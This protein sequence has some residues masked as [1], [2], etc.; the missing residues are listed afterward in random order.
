M[1]DY[2]WY[3]ALIIFTHSLLS[4]SLPAALRAWPV[5]VQHQEYILY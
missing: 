2:F 5:Q 1:W 3:A 4:H